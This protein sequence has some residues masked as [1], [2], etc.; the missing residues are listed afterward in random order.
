MK[1]YA[2]FAREAGP[3]MVSLFAVGLAMFALTF[4][5]AA[6]TNPVEEAA[7]HIAEPIGQSIGLL[8]TQCLRGWDYEPP[9]I[10]DDVAIEPRCFKEGIIVRLDPTDRKTCQTAFDSGTATRPGRGEITCEEAGY[11][12]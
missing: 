9:G 10:G 5:W 11:R 12:Q 2:Q 6:N 3:W 4:A 7:D 8:P 1:S